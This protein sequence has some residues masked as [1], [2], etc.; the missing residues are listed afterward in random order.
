MD[1]HKQPYIEELL[2]KYMS[3]KL[4]ANELQTLKQTINIHT[5]EELETYVNNN[6]QRFNI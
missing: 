6:W 2:D 3:G 1:V 4:T 5:D